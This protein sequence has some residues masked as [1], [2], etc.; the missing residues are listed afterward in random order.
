[1]EDLADDEDLSTLKPVKVSADPPEGGTCLGT[2]FYKAGKS[3]P[4]AA[5]AAE[6]WSFKAWG[7]GNALAER[8]ITVSEFDN[9]Y[10]AQ[11]I[12]NPTVTTQATPE[13]GGSVTGGGS[14]KAGDTVTLNAITNSGYRFKSWDNGTL[15]N[16]YVFRMPDE[17]ITRTATF[18]EQVQVEA[19]ADPTNGGYVLGAKTY[20]ADSLVTLSAIHYPGWRFNGWFRDGQVSNAPVLITNVPVLITVATPSL[21]GPITYTAKFVQTVAVT[22]LASPTNAGSVSGT[23]TYDVGD[24]NVTLTATAS[25]NWQF[26]SWSDAK[27][28]NPY[29]LTA[30]HTAL[31]LTA[32]FEAT[33]TITVGA[34][35]GKGGS[36]SGGGTFLV[37]SRQ[38]ISAVASNGWIFLGWSD[39]TTNNPYHIT[40]PSTNTSY[41]A[42]FTASNPP[43]IT[44]SLRSNT[45]TLQWPA[46]YV[47]WILQ[48]RA[49][50][51]GAAPSDG[52]FDVPGSAD[53]NLAAIPLD[54]AQPSVFYRLRRP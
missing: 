17:D 42:S 22:G 26:V 3:V 54:P 1:M 40:V 4:I 43:S 19:K 10:A 11:F 32:C 36:A 38:T 7:D 21:D 24:T 51:L 9:D 49:D 27:T 31:T 13:K 52:W 8:E 48:A 33:A 30:P 50:G 47:G 37:G 34:N 44:I 20:D 16:P 35:P 18:V 53:T 15:E 39:G 5:K 6:D 41:T 46:D 25:N 23:G 29:V 2:G 45:L 28:N 12:R 14:Y